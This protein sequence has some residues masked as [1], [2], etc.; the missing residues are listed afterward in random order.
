MA[1]S[2]R[3]RQGM[4]VVISGP[5][6]AGK[7][8]ICQEVL[9]LMPDVTQSVSCT[10]RAARPGEQ[11]GREY[12]FISREAFDTAVATGDF[13]EWAVVHD[14]R[15]GTLRQQVQGIT[16]DGKD[17]LLA[18]DV[19]G[20][21]NLR[22]ANVDAVYVFVVPPSWEVLVSRLQD[23]GSESERVRQ[24]RLIVAREEVR[25]YTGYDYLVINDQLEEATSLLQAIIRAE[26]QRITR[27]DMAPFDNLD[28]C[29]AAGSVALGTASDEWR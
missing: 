18:I 14:H 10:T 3:Q 4:L 11:D 19:Q 1:Q 21:V 12:H 5:S 22:S 24:R 16:A 25:H 28:Q 13:L 27:I 6:G 23:R 9:A 17:V 2:E 26:R 7:T 29:D 20:A 15:Y 8:S